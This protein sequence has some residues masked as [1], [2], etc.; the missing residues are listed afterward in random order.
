[1]FRLYAS[2]LEGCTPFFPFGN[3]D[4]VVEPCIGVSLGVL[5]A[6][7]LPSAELPLP[8]QVFIPWFDAA[9]SGRLQ[10]PQIGPVRLE[11]QAE[12]G[13]ALV[14]HRFRFDEPDVAVFEAGPDPALA[15]NVGIFVPL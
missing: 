14:T 12:I 13:S 4:W 7:G 6:R 10:S 3:A 1:V 9:L 8:G 5:Y 11:G 2:H 15:V